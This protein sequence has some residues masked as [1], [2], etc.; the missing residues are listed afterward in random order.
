MN[1]VIAGI[2][3]FL[4]KAVLGMIHKHALWCRQF[5]FFVFEKFNWEVI[6]SCCSMLETLEQM[7][8][9]KKDYVTWNWTKNNSGRFLISPM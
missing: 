2:R 4:H 5:Q 1:K 3:L 7:I 8:G 6:S 9:C